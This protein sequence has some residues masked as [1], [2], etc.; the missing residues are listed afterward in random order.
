MSQRSE[1]CIYKD[2]LRALE[3][4]TP[5]A[6]GSQGVPGSEHWVSICLCT[7]SGWK[8]GCGP[9]GPSLQDQ[10]TAVD[11]LVEPPP[12]KRIH[13]TSVVHGASRGLWFTEVSLPQAL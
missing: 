1:L 6:V 10:N 11:S 8:S 5:R 7:N 12:T 2:E 4:G 3:D 9:Q 13:L